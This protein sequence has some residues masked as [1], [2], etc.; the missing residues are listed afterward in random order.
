MPSKT[1]S[2][3]YECIYDLGTVLG[4][5]RLEDM[6]TAIKFALDNN[7]PEVA[8]YFEE[9]VKKFRWHIKKEFED[10]GDANPI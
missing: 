9:M 6:D 2:T 10:V 1:Y 4:I 3:P 8:I 5:S 7:Y